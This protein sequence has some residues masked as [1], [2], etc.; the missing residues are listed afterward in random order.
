MRQNEL[1]ISKHL[2]VGFLTQ[3]LLAL[4]SADRFLHSKKGRL[5]ARYNVSVDVVTFGIS[6]RASAR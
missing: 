2:T 3:S 1:A 5:P 4:H 6:I